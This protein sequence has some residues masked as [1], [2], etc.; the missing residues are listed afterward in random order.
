MTTGAPRPKRMP[1][2]PL[3]AAARGGLARV[4][5]READATDGPSRS[6]SEWPSKRIRDPMS[7]IHPE[8]EVSGPELMSRRM[9]SLSRV[10]RRLVVSLSTRRPIPTF[11]ELRESVDEPHAPDVVDRL[12]RSGEG[13]DRR[14]GAFLAAATFLGG[15]SGAPVLA[16]VRHGML[17]VPSAIVALLALLTALRGISRRVEAPPG[18]VGDWDTVRDAR[19]YLAV[20]RG[21]SGLTTSLLRLGATALLLEAVSVIVLR[22]LLDA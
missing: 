10:E 9:L 18:L 6:G 14:L 15:L 4:R 21:W 1:G 16:G 7:W 20:K 13:T 3:Q 17:F 5:L 22:L 11:E 12:V 8:S 2:R 19:E